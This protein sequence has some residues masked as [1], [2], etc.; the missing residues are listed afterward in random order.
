M[1]NDKIQMINE[2]QNHNV[3]IQNKG[4]VIW[5]LEFVIHL[6]FVLCN[7]TLEGVA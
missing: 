6:T 1:T 4:F 3:K 5:Y 7:L 2:I